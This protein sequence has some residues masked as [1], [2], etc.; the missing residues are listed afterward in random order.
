[1]GR[2]RTDQVGLLSGVSR[3]SSLEML[4]DM[5]LSVYILILLPFHTFARSIRLSPV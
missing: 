1:M 3:S 4:R 5:P 2:K